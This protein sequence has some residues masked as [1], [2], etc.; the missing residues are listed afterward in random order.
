MVTWGLCTSIPRTHSLLGI[1]NL[2][3]A[4]WAALVAIAENTAISLVLLLWSRVAS[5][6]LNSATFFPYW[7]AWGRISVIYYI[8]S[9]LSRFRNDYVI[10]QSCGRNKK[11]LSLVEFCSANSFLSRSFF[12][13]SR[14]LLLWHK[15]VWDKVMIQSK[16]NS[17][18]HS[19]KFLIL[20][21]LCYL[22]RYKL[23]L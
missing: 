1:L 9:H 20:I 18:C 4:L 10:Q 17:E 21:I 8:L 16:I 22:P 6:T 15:G 13:R 2:E 5:R 14:A 19:H 23:T 12:L 7:I 3:T 11:Q